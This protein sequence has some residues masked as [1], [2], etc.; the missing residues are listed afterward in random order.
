MYI[1]AN[2]KKVFAVCLLVLVSLAA[3]AQS[4]D[5][6]T[7]TVK[8]EQG[9]T[10]VGA[11]VNVVGTQ[12]KAVTNAKGQFTINATPGQT[13][14][15]SYI[16]MA[17]RRV[18]IT[19]LSMDITLYDNSH[20][21][22]E[23]VITGYQNIRNRVYTGA[24]TSVK[25]NDIKLEGIADVSRM[26]EGRVPGLSIQNISG[27]F[28]SAPR[29][30]IRGGASIIGNVQPLWVIDGAVY[31][32]LV[33]LSIDQLAS[34]DAVTLISS[35]VSGLNP[36]DIQDIQVLK[37][38]S[39]TSVYGA[40][41]LNGVIVITTKSGRKNSP[42]RISYSTENTV[43]LKP[44]Y[45]DFDLLNSQETMSLYQEMND[46][47][48]FGI[49][50]S[51]YGRRSG[52]YY[53][54]YKGISTINPATG[55]YYLPNTPD[56]KM[57][58]L[59][60]REYANTNWFDLL[61][62][63]KPIT[64][65]SITL[66]GGGKNTA[67]YA[68][69][70]FYY[71]GG[72]TIA[73]NVRRLTANIKNTFYI[74]DK[75]ITTLTA[76]GN[77]RSQK[78]PGTMPQRKNN[79]IGTFERDFDINPFSYALGTSRTLRPYNEN[80]SLEY[81]RNNWAPFNILNEYANN[82]MNINVLD[83]KLQGEATY[84]VNTDLAIKTL[85]S[86]RQAY[87]TTTHEVYEN[88]NVVQAYR[89]NENPFVAQQNIYLV[90]D[91]DNPLLQPKVG[92]THG[93]ILNKTEASLKSFLA[94]IA[95]DFDKRIDQHDVKAFAFTEIRSTVRTVNPFQGYGIQY[96]R[97]NQIYTNP[98]IFDK[99][100]NEGNS[101]FNLHK[102]NDR[103]VTFSFNGTYGYAGKYIFNMVF[104]CEGSN[105]S[106]KGARALWL[107][108][109]NIGAKWNID[110]EAFMKGNSTISRLAL[111]A[112]YGLTAKMNEEA[113]NANSIFKGGI[114][115]RYHFKDRENKLNILHLENR[116]LTWEK[117][118][119]LNIGVELGLFNNRI[120]TTLDVYQR[121]TFDLIDLVRTSGVGG[122]Y[123]KYANFGDMRTR[124][125]ELGVHTKNI[126]TE[127]FNWSTSLTL[128]AMNQKIT[129]L[130]NTPNAFDMVAG[131]GR[132]NIVGYPRGS[133][134]SFNF[135][136]LNNNGLPTF[137]FG[138]YPSSQGEYSN[139]A[140][141]D[142][143]DTQYAKSYLLYHGPIEPQVIGGLSNTLKYK[144]W[145]LSFFVT[146]QAG[147]KIRLNPTFDPEFGDL[148]VFSKSYY[149]RWLNPGDELKTDIP[150]LPS[151]ELIAKVG[152]E[153]IERAYNT[154]NYSQ[155]MV[156]DGSFVRMKNISLGYNIPDKFLKKM[157]LHTMNLRLN[158]TNPFLIY[159]DK[160]LKGQ[161]PEYYKSGGV[162]L[163][164]P[165]QYTLTLNI[166]F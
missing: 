97:G 70:G 48:Y 158:I 130:L 137:D 126:V 32:D 11:Y 146:M 138:L 129:R 143:L 47:G 135:Q 12:I 16:G 76:Q 59:R 148:N 122:Q 134:F 25:M 83:F 22:D 74:N 106:G 18:K 49:S 13:L 112:S 113:I 33:H 78:A 99:L 56:A 91:K 43:R 125:I 90:H 34:G 161:D 98:L 77:I 110:Q 31:E 94:R 54:L 105:T 96:D 73:D 115:N 89:A 147:N 68:S 140:G 7:G 52:I 153:N 42:L 136:G 123:Y 4:G 38:A 152:K 164:T 66:S 26:L 150:V 111:R 51:L 72:W 55:T 132:G 46:K 67:T 8:T 37:D 84:R 81:Y 100:I 162:S 166:G 80:G 87:T 102:R 159:S 44:R 53:Q 71:D 50:N 121:N 108:T 119:E 104:N 85:V 103:G 145:E 141:A 75:L 64:N 29:I 149:N 156:A 15:V 1:Q 5:I 57:D 101:Y 61:F 3:I 62:T 36:A 155:K 165:K 131:R 20:Q 69:I 86:T 10:L 6:I 151:Q 118:Y 60:K 23:V 14:Q 107:P 41:A 160:K 24:A 45:A 88:S 19:A 39:A 63:M 127:T 124:G 58:F 92:L 40:R 2:I 30:N 116:D 17:T 163:P 65:H 9:E 79:A 144:D 114:V 35:A 142:F 117:M 139:I 28:G 109:W 95:F 93:G 128:S 82:K 120:S 21:V 27:T 133:L 157:K 154:Y